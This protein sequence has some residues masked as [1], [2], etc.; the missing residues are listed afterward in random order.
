MSAGIEPLKTAIRIWWKIDGKRYRETLQN[1]PPTPENRKNAQATA[2]M[3]AQQI[4]LGIFDRNQVFPNSPKRAEA[5]FSYYIEQWKNDADDTVAPSSWQAYLSKVAHHIEPYWGTK[6]IAKITSTHI[7]RWVKDVLKKRLAPKT[8]KDIIMLWRTIWSYWARHQSNVADPTQFIKLG[9]RDD[10]DINPFNKDEIQTIINTEQ[11][12][13]HRNLWTVMLWSGLSSHEL[14]ALAKQDIDLD[15]H[16]LFVKR[17][18]VKNV[19]RVTK[20]RRRKRQ[21]ELL[22]IVVTALQSQIDLIKNNPPEIVKVLDRDN[23]TYQ[24]QKLTWLWHN[25]RTNTHI[26]YPQLEKRWQKH[27]VKCGV[28]YRPPNHGRHTYASQV[29]SSGAVSAEWLANQLGHASTEMI[30]KHY[31]K[32]IPKDSQHI[33]DRLNQAINNP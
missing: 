18:F 1:T 2:D 10:D 25:P 19:H 5:Y 27:L 33:I 12:P 22:P 4:K 9:K 8:I 16:R 32:F 17:G 6:L 15:N 30:H 23:I 24:S 13:T 31:G 29:L 20:N 28:E 3:I 26:T 14:I 7:E 11:D 21:V